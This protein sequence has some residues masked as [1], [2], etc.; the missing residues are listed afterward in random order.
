MRIPELWETS[1]LMEFSCICNH[2]FGTLLCGLYYFIS[3]GFLLSLVRVLEEQ[4][5]KED[6]AGKEKTNVNKEI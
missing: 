2:L 4:R 6:K 3:H 5:K 1:L